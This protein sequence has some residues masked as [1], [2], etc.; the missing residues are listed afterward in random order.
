MCMRRGFG[1][2]EEGNV[3]LEEM[4]ERLR[5]GIGIGIGLGW[6]RGVL[7]AEMR[8]LALMAVKAFRG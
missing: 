8:Q 7:E 3:V 4:N 2:K 1:G 6:G 5:L